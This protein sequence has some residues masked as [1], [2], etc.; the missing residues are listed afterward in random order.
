MI[1]ERLFKGSSAVQLENE[2]LRVIILPSIGGKV[3]SIYKKDKN[4]ELLFQN[5][6]DHYAKPSLYAPFEEYDAAGFDDAFPTI[7]SC[8]VTFNNK[9][10]LYP[11]HGEIWSG[12]FQY[13]IMGEQVYLEY[14]SQILDY[15]YTKTFSL[16]GETLVCKYKILN[17]GDDSFPFIWAFHCLVRC[18]EDMELFFPQGTKEVVAV[19]NSSILGPVGTIHTYPITR[20]LQGETCFLNKVLPA[21]SRST[22]KYYVNGMVDE[23]SCGIYY[24][25]QDI[26]YT[27]HFDKEKLPYLGFW[28]TE[29]GFRG[30]YNCALEPTNGYYDDIHIAAKH[31]SLYFLEPGQP[32][33]FEIRIE[34]K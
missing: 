25:K 8:M 34:L 5:K 11:D 1:K 26:H 30:D 4:F 14:N 28:V 32:F 9:E 3:A 27:I 19:Q 10:I 12:E 6:K 20:N 15:E 29:G 24:P 18:E 21:S 23:G 13:K 16:E 2:L 33:V 31:Q 7:D 22:K 17:T